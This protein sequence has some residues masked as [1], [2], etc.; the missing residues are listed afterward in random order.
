MNLIILLD[1]AICYRILI[2]S[3]LYD[4]ILYD[5]WNTIVQNVNKNNIA[6]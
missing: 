1:L 6:T 5:D 2:G 4:G 3:T